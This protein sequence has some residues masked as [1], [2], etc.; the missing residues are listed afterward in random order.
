MATPEETA[1]WLGN[2]LV[3]FGLRPP[4]GSAQNSNSNP[5]IVAGT[6]DQVEEIDTMEMDHLQMTEQ[7]LHDQ[8]MAAMTQPQR[9]AMVKKLGALMR[10]KLSSKDNS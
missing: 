9:A 6:S 4:Q 3:I 2:G 5:D 10:S 1:A 8:R 7:E